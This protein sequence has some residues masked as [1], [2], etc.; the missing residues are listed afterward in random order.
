MSMMLLS[1]CVTGAG[2][3]KVAAAEAKPA[4][5]S[6][7]EQLAAALNA[8]AETNARKP[9]GYRDPMVRTASGKMMQLAAAQEPGVAPQTFDSPSLPGSAASAPASIAGLATQP[10]AVNANRTSIYSSATSPVPNMVPGQPDGSLAGPGAAYATPAGITPMLRSV[11][12][13]SPSMAPAMMPQQVVP[14]FPADQSSQNTAPPAVPQTAHVALA[15]AR[16]NS[17]ATPSRIMPAPSS[18]AKTLDSKEALMVAHMVASGNQGQ[19]HN[20]DQG[21][22]HAVIMGKPLPKGVIMGVPV[23]PGVAASMKQPI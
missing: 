22:G 10:T 2:K 16:P 13:A 1:G 6:A 15:G 8:R 14:I 23:T 12:S 7:A 5:P 18:R 21:K 20:Q 9:G 11:Y 19:G 3:P 4:P 17:D